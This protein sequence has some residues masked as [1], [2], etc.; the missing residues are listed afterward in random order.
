M[1]I[2]LNV[3]DPGHYAEQIMKNGV[4]KKLTAMCRKKKYNVAVF[5]SDTNTNPFEVPLQKILP[6]VKAK[7]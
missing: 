7:T 4:A 1:M 6:K 5:P 2:G 3:V